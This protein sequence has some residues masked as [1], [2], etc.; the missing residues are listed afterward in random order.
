MKCSQEPGLRYHVPAHRIP[1]G[2][3]SEIDEGTWFRAL[4]SI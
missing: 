4:S 2:W 1:I 3:Q